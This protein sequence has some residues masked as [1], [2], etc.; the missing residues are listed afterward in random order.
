MHSHAVLPSFLP[1]FLPVYR[2]GGG[3]AALL[4]VRVEVECFEIVYLSLW[5]GTFTLLCDPIY[6]DDE[7][8][9]THVMG[10]GSQHLTQHLHEHCALLRVSRCLET[11][12]AG[13]QGHHVP[14]RKLLGWCTVV[15]HMWFNEPSAAVISKE[16]LGFIAESRTVVVCEVVPHVFQFHNRPVP[17][18]E[19]QFILPVAQDE[20]DE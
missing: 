14:G 12:D 1:S 7:L 15:L 9:H 8:L 6:L 16:E 19:V 17:A 3:M 5:S 2:R 4:L 13:I 10:V 11:I 20:H 18:G